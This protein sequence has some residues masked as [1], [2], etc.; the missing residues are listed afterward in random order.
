MAIAWP[1]DLVLRRSSR[2][3]ALLRVRLPRPWRA[4]WFCSFLF[5]P[6]WPGRRGTPDEGSWQARKGGSGEKPGPRGDLGPAGPGALFSSAD[7]LLFASRGRAP[8]VRQ[9]GGCPGLELAWLSLAG[10]KGA[11]TARLGGRGGGI[12]GV[13][14]ALGDA[15]ALKPDFSADLLPQSVRLPRTPVLPGGD[16]GPPSGREGRG[17]Y[18]CS[19]GGAHS[20]LR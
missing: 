9:P 11:I 8:S 17:T 7:L 20:S 3:R 10:G 6:G 1:W 4:S 5:G 14:G 16:H 2:G 18:T 12:G 19:L 13:R 15:P